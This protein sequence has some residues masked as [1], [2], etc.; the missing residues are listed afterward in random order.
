MFRLFPSRVSCVISSIPQ[1][2]FPLTPAQCFVA[3]ATGDS[4]S[5]RAHRPLN[6]KAKSKKA[7]LETLLVPEPPV[8]VMGPSPVHQCGISRYSNPRRPRPNCRAAA[9]SR[10]DVALVSENCPDTT[11]RP[12]QASNNLEAK[13]TK[14]NIKL[15]I[16]P[17]PC[18][19][20]P[21][22]AVRVGFT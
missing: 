14:L 15:L 9:A 20:L 17:L 4:A 8:I 7:R 3:G 6:R 1:K 16:P 12:A 2:R 11:A 5:W 13:L 22:L 19:P 10:V 18:C 21:C